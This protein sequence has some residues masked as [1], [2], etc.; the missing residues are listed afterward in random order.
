VD[1]NSRVFNL[2]NGFLKQTEAKST[3][4]IVL[5]EFAKELMRRGRAIMVY[6]LR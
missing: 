2:A 4:P 3:K 5:T 1:H 6:R